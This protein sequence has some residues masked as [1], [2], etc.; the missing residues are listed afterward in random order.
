MQSAEIP[1]AESP[2][3]RS[4]H[5]G[6][7]NGVL[8]VEQ[9]G[10]GGVAD[11]TGCLAAALARRGVPVTLATAHDNRY[12]PVAGVRVVPVFHYVRGHSAAARLARRARLGPALNGLRFL[13]SLPRLLALARQARVVH[14]QGFE[15]VA[16]GLVAMSLLRLVNPR[17][18]LTLHNAFDRHDAPLSSVRIYPVLAARTIVHTRGDREALGRD[19]EVIPHG[20]YGGVAEGARPVAPELARRDLGIGEDV[21]VVLMF[22][23]LRRD[24]GIEDLL[25]AVARTP[26]WVALIAGEED[27]GLAAAAGALAR[28]ELAGRTHVFPGFHDLDAVARFF[29]AA[30]LVAIPYRQA[31]QSGVLHLAYG[32]GRPVVA[33]PVGGLVEAVL[34]GETGWLCESA[35]PDALADVL[36]QAAALGREELRRRGEAGREWSRR[37]FDWDRIAA[38]TEAVYARTAAPSG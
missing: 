1:S 28:P 31:S 17:I 11:Y 36:A 21:P 26:P 19:A 25:H 16:L 23:H 32:F 3:P 14:L 37:Q 20:H 12:P 6:T 22:G 10:R 27:G 9:G 4:A 5:D 24:K 34:P 13:A 2:P 33:Y 15:H 29:A 38:D 8:V 30:D 35:S 18:V 7:R